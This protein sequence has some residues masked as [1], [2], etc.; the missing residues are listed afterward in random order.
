MGLVST[1]PLLLPLFSAPI[2]IVFA[3]ARSSFFSGFRTAESGRAGSLLVGT[4][5]RAVRQQQLESRSFY[6]S[7][8]PGFRFPPS[9]QLHSPSTATTS[10]SHRNNPSTNDCRRALWPCT[11]PRCRSSTPRFSHRS[12]CLD[13]VEAHCTSGAV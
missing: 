6:F 13:A 3:L 11:A 1:L 4:S 10:R 9:L 8:T 7:C 5:F 2:P 12:V